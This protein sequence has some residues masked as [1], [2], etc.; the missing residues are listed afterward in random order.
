MRRVTVT[1]LASEGLGASAGLRVGDVLLSYNGAPLFDLSE[2]VKC[3]ESFNGPGM[4]DL[5]VWRQGR[6]VRIA[7]P[8]GRLGVS[9]EGIELPD[10]AFHNVEAVH[11]TLSSGERFSVKEVA[12]VNVQK[13]N[14]A[15]QLYRMAQENFKGWTSPIGFLGSPSWVMM[16]VGLTTMLENSTS[17]KMAKEGERQLN[18]SLLVLQALRSSS[19]FVEVSRISNIQYPNPGGWIA[20]GS[21]EETLAHDGEQYFNARLVD[22]REVS[23]FAGQITSYEVNGQ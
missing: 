12:L 19:Q 21:N 2:L 7:T 4:A 1:S 14:E 13:L 17:N 23:I 20:T 11:I 9:V 15:R 8:C 16:G 22:G 18:D 5:S 3:V 6:I 10:S